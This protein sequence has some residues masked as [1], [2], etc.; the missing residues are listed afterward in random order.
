MVDCHLFEHPPFL[1]DNGPI[2]TNSAASHMGLAPQF[3]IAGDLSVQ[4][5]ASGAVVKLLLS[6]VQSPLRSTMGRGLHS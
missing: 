6:V 1:R 2:E 3:S 5:F 4:R